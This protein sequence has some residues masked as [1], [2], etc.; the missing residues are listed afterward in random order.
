MTAV[1]NRIAAPRQA[2]SQVASIRRALL[3]QIAQGLPEDGRLPAERQLSEQFATTRITLREALLQLEA[4]GVLYREERRGW[5]VAPPR[6]HYDPTARGYFER[7]VREQSRTPHTRLLHV[8][9]MA[10][11]PT[12]AALLD[13]EP[14]A[15]VYMIRR[16]RSI[17]G[18]RVLFVEHY[19]NS[20][21]FPHF[22][23]FGDKALS[24]SL[25]EL[26]RRYYDI[27]YGRVR[28]EI[29]PAALPELPA[30]VL[31]VAAGSP[32]LY[33]Q[34][35]NADQHGRWIDCDLEYWRQ[36]AIKVCIEA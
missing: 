15:P 27:E 9:S 31:K 14:L 26:Y 23:R 3:A 19:L 1:Q 21:C 30:R 36:D 25:T 18:R 33:V 2:V 7:M 28:F 22:E 13:I 17:D 32:A 8:E 6:L 29:T 5:F 24:R 35:V 34:R 10:A 20:A 16:A 11:T 12:I 4:D